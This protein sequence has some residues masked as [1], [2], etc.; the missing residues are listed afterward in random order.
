MDLFALLVHGPGMQVYSEIAASHI[1]TIHE[2]SGLQKA[3]ENKTKMKQRVTISLL[4][5]LLTTAF[6]LGKNFGLKLVI[7]HIYVNFKS[8][9]DVVLI[10]RHSNA[11]YMVNRY[12]L[13]VHPGIMYGLLHRLHLT[14]DLCVICCS[15]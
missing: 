7:I 12:I 6:G 10:E 4:I 1:L 14:T 9:G 8:A 11:M 15:F 13:P 3:E 2:W 5:V